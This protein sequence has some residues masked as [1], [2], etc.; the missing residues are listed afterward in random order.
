MIQPIVEGQGEVLATRDLITRIAA[1]FW[2]SDIYVEV[3]RPILIHRTKISIAPELENRIELAR[4]K[5]RTSD[6]KGGI[7]VLFD[8]DDDCPATLAPELLKRAK[9]ASADLPIRVVMAHREYESWFLAATTSIHQLGNAPPHPN[10]ESKRGAKEWLSQ[11]MT[12]NYEPTYYQTSFTAQ[13]DLH[14]AR[15]AAPSFDKLCRDL[16]GMLTELSNS[17]LPPSSS[18]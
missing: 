2:N 12:D 18:R 10:P 16:T 5:V 15:A 14:A 8:S 3:L 4:Q 9:V 1:T 6:S 7:L 17:P 13:F 11:L